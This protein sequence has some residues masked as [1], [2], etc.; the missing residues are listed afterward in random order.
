[1]VSITGAPAAAAPVPAP[2]AAAPV[3]APSAAAAPSAPAA[4]VEESSAPAAAAAAQPTKEPSSAPSGAPEPAAAQDEPA[5]G[6]DLLT[7]RRMWPDVLEVVKGMRRFTWTLLSHNA[8]VAGLE[9][10]RLTL[11]MVNA[12]ARDSFLRGG[13]DEIVREALI[14]VLGVDWK[15]DAVV[16]PATQPGGSASAAPASA[17]AAPPAPAGG[18]RA[19]A[20]A[21]VAEEAAATADTPATEDTPSADDEDADES[22]LTHQDLLARELGAKVIGEYDAS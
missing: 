1:R 15:V 14:Q 7:V 20:M 10:G 17:P 21:A 18:G 11:A 12:G 8:Q 22:G 2:S 16:D 5:G 4:P 9:S 19:A 13:S 6:V 3:P